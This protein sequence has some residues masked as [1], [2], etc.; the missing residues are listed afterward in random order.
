MPSGTVIS[1]NDISG[2]GLIEPDDGSGKVFVSY[3]EV[4]Q[5]GY[6][7]LDEGQRVNYQKIKGLTGRTFAKNVISG[8]FKLKLPK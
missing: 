7:I 4:K 3:K 8:Q 5:K 2:E 1:F 6:K